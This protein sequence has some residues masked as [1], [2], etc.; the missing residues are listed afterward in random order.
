MARSNSYKHMTK[1]AD[2]F[3]YS[4]SYSVSLCFP[5]MHKINVVHTTHTHITTLSHSLNQSLIK[6]QRMGGWYY[7]VPLPKYMTTALYSRLV[8]H[9]EKENENDTRKKITYESRRRL[10]NDS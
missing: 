6:Q 10:Y 4:I 7:K 2:Q 1:M 3:K 5:D 9:T 8:P